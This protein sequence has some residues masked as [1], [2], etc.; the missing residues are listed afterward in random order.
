LKNKSYRWLV[1]AMLCIVGALNYIDRMMLTTMRGSI[2]EAIPMTD[3]QFGLLTAVFLWVYGILSPF[4]GFLADRFNRS[5]VIIGG[6]FVWSVVTWLTSHATTFE[7]LLVARALMGISESCYAPAALALIMDYHKGATRSLA[8]GIHIGGIM[9]GQSMGFVGGWLA[10]DHD[11]SYPFMIFGVIGVSYSLI[12]LFALEDA[13]KNPMMNQP[14]VKHQKVR[15]GEALK[16]LFGRRAFI[17]ALITWGLLGIVGWIIAGWL[18]TYFKE[19]FNL[20]QTMAGVY[21]TG[22]FHAAS[23]VGVIVGGFL[24][25]R[26]ARKNP[27]AIIL[28][29]VIG[30][31]I[32][33]PAIFIASSSTVLALAI[34]CF[35]LYSFTRIFTDGNMMPI[36]C[37]ITDER[38]RATAYG[39]SNFFSCIVGGVGLYAGGALRDANIG[40][41]TLFKTCA[42]LLAVCA[43]LLYSIKS[44]PENL[45]GTDSNS[46]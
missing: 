31:C 26:W 22:Y 3:A 43:I 5:R 11:W 36:L 23:F 21:S 16:D 35:M 45:A 10:S 34:F 6:L 2:V 17:L 7:D 32:A 27:N 4:A 29:P 24:A 39:G 38:Y 25:D 40:L 1:V 15:F 44:S 20:S 42:V 9:V 8:N 14:E 12:L 33:A 30:L 28:L 19:S 13:P 37:L 46:K 41:S 18:P